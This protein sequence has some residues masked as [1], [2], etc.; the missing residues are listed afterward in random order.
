MKLFMTVGMILSLAVPSCAQQAQ[1][2]WGDAAGVP[3]T[4]GEKIS[5][6]PPV[7]G[8]EDPPAAREAEKPVQDVQP[9][10]APP[11]SP[12]VKE[13]V[14]NVPP[15]QMPPAAQGPVR[16]VQAIPLLS[17]AAAGDGSLVLRKHEVEKGETLS[18]LSDKYY[19][20]PLKWGAIFNANIDKISNPDLIYPKE[21]I[22][23]PVIIDTVKTGPFSA[24]GADGAAAGKSSSRT[25]GK[26]NITDFELTDLSMEMP[27]DQKEWFAGNTAVVPETWQEDG[28]I[29]ARIGAGAEEENESLTVPG[30][31]V[32]IRVLNPDSFRIGERISVYMKGAAAYDKKTNMK[33]GRELQKTGVLEVLSVDKN[34]VKARIAESNTTVDNGQV[35]KR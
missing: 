29:I 8:Y 1:L 5:E 20:D 35:I 15:A 14:Q 18:R 17:K 27:E 6:M 32:R 4:Q 21:E 3:Q 24:E 30:D 7:P 9:V 10:E 34:I 28:V 23:I 22:T 2:P 26:V 33:L 11:A 13:P 31:S 12:E 25:A 19:G 16:Y